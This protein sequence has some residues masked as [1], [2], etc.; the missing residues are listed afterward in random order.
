[1]VPWLVAI[2]L[3]MENLDATILTTMMSAIHKAILVLAGLTLVSSAW[4]TG[5]RRTDGANVSRSSEAGD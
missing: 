3:F 2:A 4:F 1:L 5:L